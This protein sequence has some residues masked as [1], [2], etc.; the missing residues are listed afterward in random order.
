MDSEDESDII[1][2][3]QYYKMGLLYTQTKELH[4]RFNQPMDLSPLKYYLVDKKWLDKYKIKNKYNSVMQKLKNNPKL[5]EYYL[6]RGE[7]EKLYKFEK[8]NLTTIDV[9][10]IIDNFF[11]VETMPIG[12]KQMTVPKN[13]ELVYEKFFEDCLNNFNQMGF[14]KTEVYIGNNDILI[15]DE[16]NKALYCCSLIPNDDNNENYNFAVKVEY[17][18]FFENIDDKNNQVGKM[19]DLNGLNNYLMKNNLDVSKTGKQIIMDGGKKMGIFWKVE[20]KNEDLYNNDVNSL[21]NNY[22]MNMNNIP[23]LNIG[24][25]NNQSN[26]IKYINNSNDNQTSSYNFAENQMKEDPKSSIKNPL[27][28][29]NNINNIKNSNEPSSI[30][31][32]NNINS[33]EQNTNSEN[34][35]DSFESPQSSHPPQPP[36]PQIFLPPQPQ[37]QQP[38]QN[39]QNNNGTQ[40]NSISTNPFSNPIFNQNEN[41][42]NININN[43]I[44][45][46]I[47]INNS[48]QGVNL[49]N[50][51]SQNNINQMNMNKNMNN[52]FI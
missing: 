41:N 40:E 22:D 24:S 4:D 17:V 27:I 26:E 52:G 30:S 20:Y 12:F 33:N 28:P 8:N 23:N 32:F 15:D 47:N 3:E 21:N 39:F 10:N 29:S 42:I 38:I 25:I 43:N 46:N 5:N 13:I 18:L 16:E 48:Q 14:H 49:N 50:P 1:R 2:N 19:A 44:N 45:N 51:F 35:I 37:P 9:E 36:Q 31:E 11:S 6:A 7:L 34:K